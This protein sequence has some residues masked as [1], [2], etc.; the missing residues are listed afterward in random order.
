MQE[1]SFLPP[2]HADI[3]VD[4]EQK[5]QM[6]SVGLGSASMMRVGLP[7][8]WVVVAS[9]STSTIKYSPG[10]LCVLCPGLVCM[11]PALLSPMPPPGPKQACVY[12]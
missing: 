11:L 4:F 10:G 3:Q 8:T 1:I 7:H 9:A 5:N 12:W 2:L 6:D